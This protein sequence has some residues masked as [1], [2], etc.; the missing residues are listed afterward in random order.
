MIQKRQVPIL[1][2]LVFLL[3]CNKT[4]VSPGAK[5]DGT[6]RASRLVSAQSKFG[7]ANKLICVDVIDCL[8]R[9]SSSVNPLYIRRLA[10]FGLWHYRNSDGRVCEFMKSAAIDRSVGL[11][12]QNIVENNCGFDPETSLPLTSD[13]EKKLESA[14]ASIELIRIAENSAVRSEVRALAIEKIDSLNESQF[15][16]FEMLF[17]LVNDVEPDV[18]HAALLQVALLASFVS[19][20]AEMLVDR[21]I[22]SVLLRYDSDLSFA[23]KA[24]ARIHTSSETENV[25]VNLLENKSLEVLIPVASA[26]YLNGFRNRQITRILLDC[27][28]DEPSGGCAQSLDS[29]NARARALLVGELSS[30]ISRVRKNVLWQIARIRGTVFGVPEN[31]WA[32]ALVEP[33]KKDIV[34]ALEVLDYN[35]EKILEDEPLIRDVLAAISSKNERC[36]FVKINELLKNDPYRGLLS[37]AAIGSNASRFIDNV[38]PLFNRKDLRKLAI[39]AAALASDEKNKVKVF[40]AIWHLANSAECEDLVVFMGAALNVLNSENE[41]LSYLRND[42]LCVQ[43]VGLRSINLAK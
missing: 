34:H 33:Y 27:L 16:E 5:S 14:S 8:G 36:D 11:I 1:L 18:R 6:S 15:K 4:V 40:D 38:L 30:P 37:V 20:K 10:L 9:L 13:E 2:S 43:E 17:G 35:S 25:L 22:R 28:A 12:A 26:L 3:S 24:A 31:M 32:L 21:K 41:V 7:V 42:S 39:L 29:C 19:P 23:A